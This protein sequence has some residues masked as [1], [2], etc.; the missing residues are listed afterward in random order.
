VYIHNQSLHKADKKDKSCG[1]IT[2]HNHNPV[3]CNV[4]T[5]NN[6]G[7]LSKSMQGPLA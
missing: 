7:P 2:L 1:T 3:P 6:H 5:Q 4:S